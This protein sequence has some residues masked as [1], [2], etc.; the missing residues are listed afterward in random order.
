MLTVSAAPFC[1]AF[2]IASNASTNDFPC[3]IAD[4]NDKI[5]GSSASSIVLS[6]GRP[7]NIHHPF[8]ASFKHGKKLCCIYSLLRIARPMLLKKVP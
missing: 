6:P 3:S 1:A 2:A 5:A 7:P 8:H 4:L